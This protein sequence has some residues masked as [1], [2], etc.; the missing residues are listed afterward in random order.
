MTRAMTW[1][2]P[3]AGDTHE[4]GEQQPASQDLAPEVTSPRWWRPMAILKPG[5]ELAGYQVV[6]FAG[7]GGMGEIYRA[8][9]VSIDREV[10]LKILN[11]AL[12]AK[13]P[14]FAEQFKAEARAA[15]RLNHPNIIAV[16]DV[17]QTTVGQT[18]I[19]Y[20]SMEFVD[21]ENLKTRIDRDGP[22]QIELV[23]EIMQAMADALMYAARM[24]MIHRDIKPENLMLTS[25]GHLKLADFG[26][27]MQVEDSDTNESAALSAAGGDAKKRKVMGTPRYMSPEQARGRPLDHR[28]DQYSLGA[29]LFHLMTGQPPYRISDAREL[30]KAHVREPVPD[31]FDVRAVPEAWRRL[32]MRLMARIRVSASPKP[33]ISAKQWMPPFVANFA[34][35]PGA[36][37]ACKAGAVAAGATAAETR[38]KT[39]C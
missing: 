11:P 27:A 28:S 21:G 3:Q 6:G 26:L 34:H 39:R 31:P 15:G 38:P 22:I 19:H 36:A 7:R 20:F 23:G 30:M 10:A 16:H 1:S 24:S 13:D 5:Q 18:A 29:T 14:R 2:H 33:R 17:G 32:C 8:R 12:V 37:G 25:D 9:Q 35:Q 4:A